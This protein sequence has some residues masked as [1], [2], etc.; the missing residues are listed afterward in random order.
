M[1]RHYICLIILPH[2]TDLCRAIFFKEIEYQ[3]TPFY[4]QSTM[5]SFQR[6]M[7]SN[8]QSHLWQPQTK[9]YH[10][11]YH[12]F[13][14]KCF[15]WNTVTQNRYNLGLLFLIPYKCTFI[16]SKNEVIVLIDVNNTHKTKKTEYFW[17]NLRSGILRWNNSKCIFHWLNFKQHEVNDGLK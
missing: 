13:K 7:M 1:R 6:K 12:L 9:R 2:P 3:W 17:N 14:Q 15:I 11:R 16:G 4:L 5:A 8:L 10:Y